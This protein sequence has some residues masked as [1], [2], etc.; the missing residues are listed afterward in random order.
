MATATQKHT[1]KEIR[2]HV[3][4]QLTEHLAAQP[5]SVQSAHRWMR[6]VEAIGLGIVLAAFAYA[7]YGSFAWAKTSP[8]LIAPAWLAFATCLSL[9]TSLFGLHAIL[10]HAF[11]TVILPGK[12]QKFITGSSATW[13]GAFAVVGGL[14]MA[15]LWIGFAYSAVTFD[16]AMIAPLSNI[17][18]VVLTIVILYS[19]YQKFTQSR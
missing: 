19:L 11:P 7:L 8:I 6:R 3:K 10:I 9:M 15:G 17:L 12:P 14:L 5:Q 16:L 13:T 1:D 4:A 18:G 2:A